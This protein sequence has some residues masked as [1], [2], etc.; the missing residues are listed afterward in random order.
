MKEKLKNELF[1]IIHS[2]I[3][4]INEK[5]EIKNKILI[6]DKEIWDSIEKIELDS[7]SW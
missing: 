5:R 6:L 2:T 7:S 1:H 4:H 3:W